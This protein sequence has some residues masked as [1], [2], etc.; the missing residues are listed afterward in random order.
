MERTA[1]AKVIDM[2]LYFA[3]VRRSR[4]LDVMHT[5]L[6]LWT[7]YMAIGALVMYAVLRLVFCAGVPVGTYSGPLVLLWPVSLLLLA[8]SYFSDILLWQGE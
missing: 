2:T 7:Q 8:T 5:V 1:Q 3:Q 6:G 4:R